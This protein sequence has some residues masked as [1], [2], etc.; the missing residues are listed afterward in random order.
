LKSSQF[1]LGA[2]VINRVIA[3]IS[4]VRS[5]SANNRSVQALS[6]WRLNARVPGGMLAADGIELT[7][8]N[9]F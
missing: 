1:V 3:A 7:F 9:E 5:V 8:S 4:A 6:S 2:L